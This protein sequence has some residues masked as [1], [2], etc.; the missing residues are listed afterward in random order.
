MRELL[1]RLRDQLRRIGGKQ[2]E[3]AGSRLCQRGPAAF[4]KLFRRLFRLGNSGHGHLP[5]N[6]FTFR[7]GNK[8][9]IGIKEV[10]INQ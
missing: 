7:A 5:V 4:E 9:M 1:G 6:Q 3:S 10:C 8:S 2:V